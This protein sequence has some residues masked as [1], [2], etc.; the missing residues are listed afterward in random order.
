M[1]QF[2]K[3]KTNSYC[4]GS[5][6]YSS[7][8]PNSIEGSTAPNGRKYLK[9]KCSK[10]GKT[11]TMMISEST[12]EGEGLQSFFKNIYNKG[13]KPA[14]RTVAK[15]VANNPQKFLTEVG[16]LV[17]AIPTTKTNPSATAK[18]GYDVVKFLTTGKGVKLGTI[19]SNGCG[20]YLHR[21]K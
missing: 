9:G 16:E 12:I 13:I 20:L 7:T 21:K 5:K 18:E 17:A 6:H 11:K 15:N 1:S 4:V 19:K 3:F 14:A 2:N 10:C 8:D